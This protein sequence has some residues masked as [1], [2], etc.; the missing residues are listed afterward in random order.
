MTMQI[1]F[2]VNFH[3]TDDGGTSNIALRFRSI[4]SSQSTTEF[5]ALGRT[6]LPQFCVFALNGIFK[7]VS[8]QRKVFLCVFFKVNVPWIAEQDTENRADE[9]FSKAKH[10][11]RRRISQIFDRYNLSYS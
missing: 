11:K 3:F 6:N 10:S 9:A 2:L 4:A 7:L 5:A 1:Y 8:L